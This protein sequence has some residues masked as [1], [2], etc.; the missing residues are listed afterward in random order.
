MTRVTEVRPLQVYFYSYLIHVSSTITA[1]SVVSGTANNFIKTPVY[2]RP[3]VSF[4]LARNIL[5]QE[6]FPNSHLD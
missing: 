3:S 6:L 4:Q 1:K 5:S 2:Y